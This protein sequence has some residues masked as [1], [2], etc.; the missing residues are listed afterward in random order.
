MVREALHLDGEGARGQTRTR[1][2]VRD[3]ATSEVVTTAEGNA[4]D[5]RG[6][7]DCSEVVLGHAVARN[8]PVVVVRNDRAQ[9]THEAAIGTV[10]YKELETLMARGL[11]EEAAVDVIIRGMLQ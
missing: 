2:A 10:N 4:P 9:I 3:R 11:D 6:H 8:S 1:I 7:M 5:A